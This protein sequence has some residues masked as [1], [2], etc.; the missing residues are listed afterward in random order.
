[1]FQGVEVRTMAL[2]SVTCTR[3]VAREH[4]G[5]RLSFVQGIPK[6]RN[7]EIL[8]FPGEIPESIPRIEEWDENRFN[9]MD[10]KP[11]RRPDPEGDALPHVRL[12]QALE[13]LLGDKLQ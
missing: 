7:E 10:F 11:P 2:S 6:D 5:Q 4:H 3:T 1:M 13:F 9:F 12:D 8:L